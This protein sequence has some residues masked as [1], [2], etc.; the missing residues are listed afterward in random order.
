MRT[1]IT[2]YRIRRPRIP[3][4]GILKTSELSPRDQ[5][6]VMDTALAYL[7]SWLE[8]HS[9]TQTVS[10]NV[11]L[12]APHSIQDRCVKAYS[13]ATVQLVNTISELLVQV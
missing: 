11:Y 5:L 4:D 7:L 10:T 3:Q 1:C 6:G 8:G 9:L 2:Q 13:V 12:Q